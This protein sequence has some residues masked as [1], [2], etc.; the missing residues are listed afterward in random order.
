[1][2]NDPVLG[3]LVSPDD[4]ELICDEDLPGLDDDEE[5]NK[6]DGRTVTAYTGDAL[7]AYREENKINNIIVKEEDRDLPIE[8]DEEVQRYFRPA[9]KPHSEIMRLPAD[10]DK[11]NQLL[12]DVYDG[13]AII[14]DEQKQF[15][16]AKGEFIVWI[17]WD[18]VCYEVSPRY[19]YL[20]KEDTK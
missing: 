9:Y 14:V 2:S 17:R 5:Q 15:D 7:F 4:V 8:K 3:E 1:M 19:A 12:Q 16:A 10:N 6:G 20:K 11:Y 18:S 13:K